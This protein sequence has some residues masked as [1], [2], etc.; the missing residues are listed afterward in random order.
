M[1]GNRDRLKAPIFNVSK[2]V[3][4]IIQKLRNVVIISKWAPRVAHLQLRLGTGANHEHPARARHQTVDTNC[5]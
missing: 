1:S 3:E 4:Q 2:D 5:A